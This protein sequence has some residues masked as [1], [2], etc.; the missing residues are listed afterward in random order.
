MAMANDH[1]A[2]CVG[3]I[4]TGTAVPPVEQQPGP[5][6]NDNQGSPD[7]DSFCHSTSE[8]SM[9]NGSNTISIAARWPTASGPSA[10]YS[11]AG[12]CP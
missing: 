4:L 9:A 3:L 8:T 10:T 6:R 1:N 5:H 2:S 12:A 11:R 7:P